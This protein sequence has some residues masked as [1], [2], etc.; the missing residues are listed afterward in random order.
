M[1]DS[2]D[3]QLLH[4]FCA[5]RDEDAFTR[6]VRR[7]LPMV[8]AVALRRL[9]SA[10]LAEEAA[11]NVFALLARKAAAV[12]RH[13]E[14]LGAWL[15]RTAFLEASH[16]ARKEARFSRIPA[17]SELNP[18]AAMNRP[19]VFDQLDAAL[20]ALPD[21]DRELL[22]R[23]YWKGEDFKTIATAL[24]RSVE[25]CTKRVERS[26]T[27]L[28]ARL[29]GAVPAV[30][31]ATALT[32]TKPSAAAMTTA[33]RVAEGA[34]QRA[35]SAA[36]SAGGI[37]TGGILAASLAAI[38][39]GYWMGSPPDETSPPAARRRIL[40]L[41]D[42]SPLVTAR[43][44]PPR[45]PVAR[46]ALQDVLAS[47]DAGRWGPLVEFLAEATPAE[48][49]VMLE[50]RLTYD[51]FFWEP[52]DGDYEDHPGHLMLRRWTELDPA[53]ALQWSQGVRLGGRMATELVFKEW[54][55]SAPDAAT[56]AFA[57]LP[58]PQ[59]RFVV[60]L[61]GYHR[62]TGEVEVLL[63][64][65]P[66][67]RWVLSNGSY[68]RRSEEDPAAAAALVAEALDGKLDPDRDFSRVSLA[69]SVLAKSDPQGA[70]EKAVR[71]P[72]DPMRTAA[73]AAVRHYRPFFGNGVQPDASVPR[74]WDRATLSGGMTLTL[75]VDDPGAAA[76]LV[77]AMAPG[78]DRDAA[79]ASLVS[80]WANVDPWRLLDVLGSLRG[81]VAN[82]TD[83]MA[84]RGFPGGVSGTGM[85]SAT[86]PDWHTGRAFYAAALDDP[87]R[88]LELVPEIAPLFI[89]RG[90]RGSSHPAVQ[91]FLG[92]V[93]NGWVFKDRDDAAA[94]FAALPE[95]DRRIVIEKFQ[96]QFVL[97]P[98]TEQFLHSIPR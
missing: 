97:T 25:S 41:E 66:K 87:R 46:P 81:T 22:L 69:F 1:P 18:A 45:E 20:L 62:V 5:R 92:R 12:A 95:D 65:F 74:S 47:I 59:Q 16:L 77:K 7:Y 51:S 60:E 49:R 64:A 63:A 57:G 19:E 71:L 10:T 28:G 53:E 78:S 96:D 43:P 2:D 17:H 50:D 34:L 80:T 93:L 11:Q 44:L 42:R 37:L 35:G 55:K 8:Q 3:S 86:E 24:G 76:A 56:A 94:W 70:M 31:A 89:K 29:G 26:L 72:A 27:K 6:L 13:P 48:L 14:R 4:D 84:V 32:A 52:G 85:N 21:T 75:A 9:R 73:L 68:Q 23:R 58:A 36:G 61:M 54:L 79:V 67:L 88:A 83:T 30:A 82:G 38:V 91:I 33:Q 90:R 39:C 40:P 15:H 98:E